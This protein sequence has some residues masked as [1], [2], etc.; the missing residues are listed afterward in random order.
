MAF[1]KAYE[2]S[3]AAEQDLE[4]IFDYTL[5]KFGLHQAVEYLSEFEIFFA[6]LVSNPRIGKNRN[7]IRPGLKSFSKSS[8]IVF[9][10]IL[11]DRIRIVRILHGSRDMP[12]F[13]ER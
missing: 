6:N 13:F 3:L 5:E 9:Y 12:K 1:P 4:E 7:E 10:R 11:N 8:H 2:L